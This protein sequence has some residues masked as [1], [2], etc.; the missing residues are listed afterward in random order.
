MSS[1]FELLAKWPIFELTECKL[2]AVRNL[3][4]NKVTMLGLRACEV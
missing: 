2:A 3:I 1:W 4:P